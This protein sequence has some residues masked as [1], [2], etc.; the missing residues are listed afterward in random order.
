M[1]RRIPVISHR[2]TQVELVPSRVA[3]MHE[4]THHQLHLH[5][6]V[7]APTAAVMQDPIPGSYQVQHSTRAFDRK[8]CLL[9]VQTVG[10]SVAQ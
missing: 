2:E 5:V 1:A 4:L 9:F 6:A 8:L 10:G 3:K 7:G